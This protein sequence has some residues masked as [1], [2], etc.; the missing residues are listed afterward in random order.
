MIH[1]PYCACCHFSNES[2]DHIPSPVNYSVSFS[3]QKYP[4]TKWLTWGS[5]TEVEWNQKRLQ[6]WID[7][8]SDNQLMFL[9][10]RKVP[11]RSNGAVSHHRH[12]MPVPSEAMADQFQCL[13]QMGDGHVPTSQHDKCPILSDKNWL[14]MTGI[15]GGLPEY[16]QQFHTYNK[17][18][19]HLF[20]FVCLGGWVQVQKTDGPTKNFNLIPLCCCLLNRDS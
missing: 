4:L 3:H 12:R 8:D 2:G 13:S 17:L 14:T 18:S 20:T 16:I 11:S 1:I 19:K 9:G 7:S 10:W 5:E 15:S 6:F